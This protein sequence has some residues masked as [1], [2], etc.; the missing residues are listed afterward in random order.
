MAAPRASWKG[1]LTIAEVTLPVALYAA[2]SSSERIALHTVN[3]TTG[4][5]VHRQYVDLETGEPVEPDDQVKGYEVAKDQ[6]VM[7]DPE[8]IA[9]ATPASDKKLTVSAFVDVEEIDDI[10]LDRPYFLAPSDRSGDA[11]FQLICEGLRAS[12]AAAIA[13]AVLFRRVRTLLIRAHEGGLA[14]ATLRFDYQTRPAKEAFADVPSIKIKREMLD[15]AEHIIK[16]KQSVF[17]PASVSDRYEVSARRTGQGEARGAHDRGAKASEAPGGERPDDGAAR[18]RQ[19]RVRSRAPR[20]CEPRSLRRRS[21]ARGGKRADDGARA[22]SRQAQ[23]RCDARAE[24]DDGAGAG[25]TQF[26][27][28][29]AR[30]APVALRFPA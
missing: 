28:P 14:A 12:G 20:N 5:R 17:D 30:R 3:R 16:T 7:L 26:R 13:G 27:R 1:F 24:A 10:Y 23:F 6:Y 11:A 22:V 4:S 29:E 25:R 8:E 18:K 9:A 15:L 19:Y 21:R 2:A